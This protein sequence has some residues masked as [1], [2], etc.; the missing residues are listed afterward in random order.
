M[1]LKKIEKDTERFEWFKSNRTV[2]GK[3]DLDQFPDQWKAKSLIDGIFRRLVTCAQFGRVL[4]VEQDKKVP[5]KGNTI[6]NAAER[7]E[8]NSFMINGIVFILM[9][10]SQYRIYM[11]LESENMQKE[12]DAS[13]RKML[14]QQPRNRDQSDRFRMERDAAETEYR[15]GK[16]TG[17][18][19]DFFFTE[20]LPLY[21]DRYV[22]DSVAK[23]LAGSGYYADPNTEKGITDR[24]MIRTGELWQEYR[25]WCKSAGYV[26]KYIKDFSIRMAEMGFLRRYSGGRCFDTWKVDESGTDEMAVQAVLD[27][28]RAE[29]QRQADEK[30]RFEE[31]M[32]ERMERARDAAMNEPDTNFLLGI[33]PGRYWGKE[34]HG[35]YVAWCDERRQE[36]MGSRKFYAWLC[37]NGFSRETEGGKLWLELK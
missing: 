18:D 5:I 20:I 11:D 24:V 2:T 23:W 1:T 34:L 3:M 27:K 16:L 7:G 8:L 30:E 21:E 32:K 25:K 14:M 10:E 31:M 36:P 4:A 12:S 22:A 29:M 37:E 33:A 13:R 15:E 17:E 9:T 28:S 6:H 35:R 26:P 19:W